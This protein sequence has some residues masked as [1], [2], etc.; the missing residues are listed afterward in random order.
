LRLLEQLVRG[1]GPFPIPGIAIAI[2]NARSGGLDL[3]DL[4]TPFGHREE[5]TLRPRFKERIIELD[6]HA[7]AVSSVSEISA[8]GSTTLSKIETEIAILSHL[9][10]YG[11]SV[12]V[13]LVR[14]DGRSLTPVEC[15]ESRRNSIGYAWLGGAT[16]FI[17]ASTQRKQSRACLRQALSILSRMFDSRRR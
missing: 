11:V 1:C 5:E 15:A 7:N 16:R 13:P 3:P 9:A 17:F 2:G 6:L 12:S 10:R 4:A 8:A 14:V